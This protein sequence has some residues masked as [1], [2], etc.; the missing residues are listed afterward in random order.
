MNVDWTEFDGEAEFECRCPCGAVYKSHA[1][2]NYGDVED[3][4]RMVSRKPCPECGCT[5]PG[6]I[7]S[8]WERY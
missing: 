8:D 6:R 5:T 1:K 7:S 2:V 4:H 3:R